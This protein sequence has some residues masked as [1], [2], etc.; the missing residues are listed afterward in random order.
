MNL[1][2]HLVGLL[3]RGIGP[4]QG[5]YLHRITQHRKTRTHMHASSGIRTHDPS[6]RAAEDSKCLRLRGHWERWKTELIKIKCES[7][8][9]VKLVHDRN[10]R[11]AFFNTMTNHGTPWKQPSSYELLRKTLTSRTINLVTSVPQPS[12]I[13]Y[14]PRL[15]SSK[16]SHSDITEIKDLRCKTKP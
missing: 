5:L 2:V 13:D 1:F 7:A 6:V 4:T 16:D 12:H 10:I 14:W 8:E 9:W 15:Q 3:G 11:R